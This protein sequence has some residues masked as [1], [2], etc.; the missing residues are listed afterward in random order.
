MNFQYQIAS[1]CFS[2]T[3]FCRSQLY[4]HT[5]HVY[6]YNIAI[7]QLPFLVA[8]IVEYGLQLSQYMD[9]TW[10]IIGVVVGFAMGVILGVLL[11]LICR[12]YCLRAKKYRSCGECGE[13][14]S[15]TSK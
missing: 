6:I 5:L 4:I 3:Q 9:Y 14:Q 7:C 8:E 13:K 12:C 2:L 11:M 10:V 1:M 15:D